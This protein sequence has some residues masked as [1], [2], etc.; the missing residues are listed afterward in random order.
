MVKAIFHC[1]IKIIGRA[2]NRSVVAAAAYR[3]GEKLIDEYYGL[4]Q[5]YSKKK[6]IQFTEIM[7]PAHAPPEYSDRQTLWNA[8]EKIEKN[9]NAQLAREI[10]IA[11]PLELSRMAQINLAKEYA[12]RN[13]VDKGMIADLCFHDTGEGNPHCHILLTMRP[14]NEDKTWGT[15]QKKI[16]TLDGNGN[17]IYDPKKRQYKCKSAPSTD[18]NEQTKAEEWRSAWAEICNE[19]L[20]QSGFDKRIDHRSYERQ[21]VEQI[22]QIHMG[23]A[24]TQMERKGIRTAVGDINRQIKL[25]NATLQ[26]LKRRIG[27]LEKWCAENSPERE[28]NLIEKLLRF[29]DNGG[30][31]NQHFNINLKNFK[32]A[33]SL[34]D[35]SISIAF[36]QE[37]GISTLAE[38]SAKIKSDKLKFN[39]IAEP[40]N[41]KIERQKQLAELINKSA[42]PPK[43]WR[44]EFD[45]ISSG[46][47]KDRV[48][49]DKFANGIARMETIKMNINSLDRYE[50]QERT[51]RTKAKA[52]YLETSI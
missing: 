4:T 20:S 40:C 10:E 22:P 25:D 32:N 16:Y 34:Q 42:N 8:V 48:K 28:E 35:I 52:K 43:S 13:F 9:K 36:L 33:K 5:D 6:G 12:R 14:F 49:I 19:Y 21:G 24:A 17:K 3:A 50:N 46:L 29:K 11:L 31:F 30:K 15:K 45:E 23:A 39:E 1:Q 44:K 37:N 27:Q 38:L 47:K 7:L 41:K 2:D 51:E 26:N 18:W